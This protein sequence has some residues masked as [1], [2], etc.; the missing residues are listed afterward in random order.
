VEHVVRFTSVGGTT[1]G[2]SAAISAAIS[3]AAP[4]PG[5]AH[6][7][8]GVREQRADGDAA[9]AFAGLGVNVIVVP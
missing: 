2:F 4:T 1:I 3:S 8:G 7:T 6:R 9:W 5:P